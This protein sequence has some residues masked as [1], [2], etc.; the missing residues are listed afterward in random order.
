MNLVQ[1]SDCLSK[2]HLPTGFCNG[3][4]ILSGIWDNLLSV[5]RVIIAIPRIVRQDWKLVTVF[6]YYDGSYIRLFPKFSY[7]LK[8]RKK[9][10]FF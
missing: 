4:I 6:C 9:K 8:E 1:Y 7:T 5:V 2:H 10:N 3:E